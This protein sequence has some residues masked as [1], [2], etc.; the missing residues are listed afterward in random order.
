M[1]GTAAAAAHKTNKN[2]KVTWKRFAF[3]IHLAWLARFYAP[4]IFV[5]VH[6]MVHSSVTLWCLLLLLLLFMYERESNK[7][8][9]KK[10]FIL[11][12]WISKCSN[13]E[14]WISKSSKKVLLLL[15][16]WNLNFKWARVEK[17]TFRK[18]E[19]DDRGRRE[20]SRCLFRATWYLYFVRW[21]QATSLR[22]FCV[23]LLSNCSFFARSYLVRRLY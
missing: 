8:L 18:R 2:K 22:A 9:S 7:K 1:N 4:S 5:A 20:W 23:Q 3:E 11:H 17:F 10:L 16:Y 21:G 12:G 15:L 13:M 14:N 6:S 19:R